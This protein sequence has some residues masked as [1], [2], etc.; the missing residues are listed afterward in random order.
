MHCLHCGDCCL[1]M[2]PLSAPEPCPHIDQRGD[3]YFCGCYE[4]RPEDCVNHRFPSHVCPIGA[5]K[6]NISDPEEM[7]QRLDAGHALLKFGG[8]S[9]KEAIQKLYR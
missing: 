4:K 2:S 5:G 8:A 7:R 1:R 9:I 3:F 6:L